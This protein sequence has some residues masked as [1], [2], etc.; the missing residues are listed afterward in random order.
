[1]KL[2]R[3][4]VVVA[5]NL[6][7]IARANLSSH[8][9]K[10]VRKPSA[11]LLTFKASLISLCLNLLFSKFSSIPFFTFC[12]VYQTT[13]TEERLKDWVMSQLDRKANKNAH[14][15]GIHD[16]SYE[17]CQSVGGIHPTNRLKTVAATPTTFIN[18]EGLKH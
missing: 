5:M 8:Q 1:M 7:V 6:H 2:Q 15:L 14:M 9:S 13:P 10:L 18:Q 17:V 16:L 4:P 11:V 3:F 12:N